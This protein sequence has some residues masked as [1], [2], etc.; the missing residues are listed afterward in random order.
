MRGKTKIRGRLNRSSARTSPQSAPTHRLKTAPPKEL[1]KPTTTVHSQTKFERLA[2]M[3]DNVTPRPSKFGG[4]DIERATDNG[5]A[6][7]GFE[8]TYAQFV[9][10]LPMY[11]SYT[12][13]D[14][15]LRPNT[16]VYCDGFQH[17]A[18]LEAE[19]QDAIQGIALRSMGYRVIRLSYIDL[20]RDPIG[21]IRGVLYA[22]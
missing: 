5:A 9:V 19:Q 2:F 3:E 6:E 4:T 10:Q 12:V 17:F 21:T 8:F 7:I 22:V 16:L 18:R 13:V 20:M 14:R 15:W 11:G 1:S